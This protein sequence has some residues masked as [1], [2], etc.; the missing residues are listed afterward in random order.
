[1]LLSEEPGG[2][3]Y[4]HPVEY[5][6]HTDYSGSNTTLSDELWEAIDSSP[7][8]VALS[9]SY[10]AEHNLEKSARFPWD[11]EKGIYH[12]KAFHHLHCLVGF[13]SRGSDTN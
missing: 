8:V 2:L 11:D 13:R 3:G 7:V 9:D 10:A 6:I 4:D 12:V 5:K 1:M